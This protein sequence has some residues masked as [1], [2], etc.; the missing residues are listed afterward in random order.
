MKYN[1][2]GFTFVAPAAKREGKKYDAYKGDKYICSFGA[3]G[4]PQ[5]KDRIGHYSHLDTND[6]VRRKAY[7]DRHR[8]DNLN[9]P[10]S[11]GSMSWRLLW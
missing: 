10:L 7:R 4:Y 5:Y 1:K 3:I 6:P 11:P 8:G 2:F 9:D